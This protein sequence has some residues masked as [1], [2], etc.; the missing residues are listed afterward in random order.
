MRFFVEKRKEFCWKY[1]NLATLQKVVF[2]ESWSFCAMCI[3]DFRRFSLAQSHQ[4]KMMEVQ[5]RGSIDSTKSGSQDRRNS[6]T[7][8]IPGPANVIVPSLGGSSLPI[9]YLKSKR[10]WQPSQISFICLATL[11]CW[12]EATWL[13]FGTFLAGWLGLHWAGYDLGQSS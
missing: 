10:V 12:N 11:Q 7:V 5:W 2:P 9:L 1:R 3:V 8:V 4:R 6:S 13:L